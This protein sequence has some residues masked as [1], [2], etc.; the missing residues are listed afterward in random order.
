MILLR[1]SFIIDSIINS[2]KLHINYC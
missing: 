1:Y 2:Y